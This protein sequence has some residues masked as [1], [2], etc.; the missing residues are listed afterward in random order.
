MRIALTG[1]I[2]SGKDLIGKHLYVDYDLE[3][4]AFADDMKR[5]FHELFPWVPRD[6]KP[7]AEYQKFGEL[8]RNHYG[9]YFW[10]RHVE[11]TMRFV[12][13]RRNVK[14]IVITDLRVPAE[15]AWCRENGFVI[16]RVTAPD[17]L[18][19]A[20]A[21]EA[22]DDFSVH[23]FVHDTELHVDK[24]EVDYE[25]VNDGTIEELYEQVDEVLTKLSEVN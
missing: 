8:M 1:K 15:Y 14:G 21:L 19:M 16:I 25:I 17:E 23:D 10:I 11:D 4:V 13:N 7:R 20:R 12:E 18:R 22:G 9:E 5:F 24:F 6:P 3:R 2:R